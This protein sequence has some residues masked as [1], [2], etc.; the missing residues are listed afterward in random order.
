MLPAGHVGFLRALAR[1]VTHALRREPVHRQEG[2][3]CVERAHEDGHVIEH[4]P[5]RDRLVREGLRVK[6]PDRESHSSD[7]R[8]HSTTGMGRGNTGHKRGMRRWHG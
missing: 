1:V 8:A 2:I 3:R 5:L 6:P 7:L 4:C